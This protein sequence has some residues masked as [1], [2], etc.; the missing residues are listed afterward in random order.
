MS[1]P[2]SLVVESLE[3]KPRL[4]SYLSRVS[5]RSR[6]FIQ[7]QIESGNVRL[8]GAIVKKCGAKVRVGDTLEAQFAEAM[9]LGLIP[10]A[11]DLDIVF[12]D[13]SLLVLNKPQGMVV[14]PAAGHRGETLVHY[15]LH[16]LK[17]DSEF[18][19]SSDT[20][21]GIVHR[22]D[23][24]TSGLLLVAK[25]RRAQENLSRQF[26]DRVVK[27]E[28]EAVV[29]GKMAEQ[30]IF[31]SPI[32]RHPTD[33]KKMSS[34]TRKAR[35]ALTRFLRE[36]Q[37]AHFAHLRLFPHTGRTHQLRVHC[38]ESSHPIAAD[39]LYATRSV[40]TLTRSLVEP[41]RAILE[42]TPFPFLH[43]RAITFVHP[44][45]DR[46]LSFEA[47]R[48]AVFERLLAQ[49]KIYDSPAAR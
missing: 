10:V 3:D 47:P 12:E 29:W 40:G 4:D 32:G 8:N 25:N 34:T 9:E 6:M 5:Q 45:E 11:A 1:D 49:L 16:H 28:Y 26:K 7:E 31:D 36:T 43:A 21:P 2:F 24:G 27:K 23:R 18:I 13:E 14:H 37:Y 35:T 19:A 33:R 42:A 39:E 17:S 15:L 20:R 30:G 22:L 46:L 38:A 48:P 44:S 41:L